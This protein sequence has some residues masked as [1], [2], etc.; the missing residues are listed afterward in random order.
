MY[1]LRIRK[2]VK[3]NELYRLSDKDQSFFNQ[4]IGI[5]VQVVADNGNFKGIITSIKNKHFLCVKIVSDAILYNSKR[6]DLTIYLSLIREESFLRGLEI[7]ENFNIAKV[8]PIITDYSQYRLKSNINMH[9]NFWNA[10]I[11]KYSLQSQH[12]SAL[13]LEKPLK[14]RDIAQPENIIVGASEQFINSR[15]IT[16]ITEVNFNSAL[17]GPERGWSSEEIEYMISKKMRLVTLGSTI[18]R[19]EIALSYICS[20]KYYETSKEETER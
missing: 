5:E 9:M 7:A 18:M 15:L 13:I 20:I 10:Q 19:S 6:V 1:K 2:K 16:S 3:K 12:S 11:K 14:L 8:I 4:K 17:I